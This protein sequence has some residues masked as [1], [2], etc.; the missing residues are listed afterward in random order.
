MKRI[1]VVLA[2]AL[3]AV[4]V[5]PIASAQE[6]DDNVV[7]RVGNTQTFDTLNPTAG[8]NVNEYEVWNLQYATLTDKA[9]DDFAPIPGLAESWESSNDGLTYTYT[10]RE[11]LVWSDGE[12]LTAED[13]V[14]T[15]NTSRDQGWVNHAS[16]TQNL[17]AVVID[18]RTVEI[19]SS[20]PDPKLPT[21][22]VY[23]LPKHIWEEVA[24]DE[25]AVTAYENLDGVGSGP[26]TIDEFP[27]EQLVRMV[28]NDNYWGGRP[29]VDEIIFQIY[30][31]PDAMVAALTQGEMD[32]IYQ[33]PAASVADLET[34]PNVEVVVGF[35]GGFEEIAINGGAA[36]GQPHPALLDLEVRRA[37]NF[38]IDK[39]AVIEDLYAGLALPAT[40]I[41]PGADLKWVPEIP[42][43][44]QFT[45][46]PDRANQILDDAGYLDSD[47]DG[48]REMPDGSNPIVLRHAVHTGEDLAIPIADLFTGWMEQIGIG[49]ELSS[50]DGDQLFEV[51]VEGDYDTFYWNWVPFVDP[52]PML[53]Y[54]TAAE[55]GN[56]N[57]ANWT[58]PRYEELYLEQ[59]E[60]LDPDRRLE[61]VHE[62]LRIFY[63]SA[64]YIPLYI[65]PELQAYR[66]DRFDGWVRQPAE[67]GPVMFSN[68][69]PS[70]VLLTPVGE[71]ESGSSD[72]LLIIGGVAAVVVIGGIVLA[73]RRRSSTA[74]DRE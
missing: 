74:D 11:G 5:V 61:I 52:D 37:I 35:Q 55:V 59:K 9:V 67:V 68:T 46:D 38:A 51:I 16:T 26:F 8:F 25:V 17:T 57:D 15:V 58:D 49:V 23:I 42:E 2:A 64:V 44:E 19:T 27:N 32:A 53:S 12:P 72:T 10:L 28:A 43:D 20:V 73:M 60:E 34:E 4:S 30:T 1:V 63:D 39:E 36:E 21:M 71:S 47:G 50:Y 33:L 66:T 56:Y 31:N 3:L 41:S 6:E 7:L 13:I 65:A 62:M 48:V 54:F 40:T 69:S 24:T 45:Y 70:Y 14:W 18:D 29:A 22:D